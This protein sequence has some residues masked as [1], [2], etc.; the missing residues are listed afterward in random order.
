M[1]EF[2]HKTPLQANA[3][4]QKTTTEFSIAAMSLKL[5]CN[6]IDMQLLFFQCDLTAHWEAVRKKSLLSSILSNV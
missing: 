3:T 1:L 6:L 4:I 5:I 2:L